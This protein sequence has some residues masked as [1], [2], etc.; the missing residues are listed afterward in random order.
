MVLNR[1]TLCLNNTITKKP[2][3]DGSCFDQVEQ[4]AAA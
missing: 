1:G 2:R 3:A 4:L